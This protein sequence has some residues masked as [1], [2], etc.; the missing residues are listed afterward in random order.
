MLAVEGSLYSYFSTTKNYDLP[1]AQLFLAGDEPGLAC[2]DILEVLKAEPKDF[3]ATC[4]KAKCMFMMGDFEKSLLIW[5]SANKI[6]GNMVEVS[7][8]N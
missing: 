2:Q 8:N 7:L 6:R 3:T 5:H 4:V 1:R